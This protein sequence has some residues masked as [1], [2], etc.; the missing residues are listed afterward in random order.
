MFL[1]YCLILFCVRIEV[2]TKTPN[3]TKNY[4]TAMVSRLKPK[5]VNY[6]L[7]K[8]RNSQN[9][10]RSEDYHP[11]K[12]LKVSLVRLNLEENSNNIINDD[13]NDKFYKRFKASCI[14]YFDI[15]PMSSEISK[16]ESCNVNDVRKKQNLAPFMIKLSRAGK[17]IHQIFIA[18]QIIFICYEKMNKQ[19]VISNKISG[20]NRIIYRKELTINKIY[21]QLKKGYNVSIKQMLDVNIPEKEMLYY[22]FQPFYI[23]ERILSNIDFNILNEKYIIIEIISNFVVIDLKLKEIRQFMNSNQKIH[24]ENLRDDIAIT[25]TLNDIQILLLMA[26]SNIEELVLLKTT[27]KK[28]MMFE[29]FANISDMCDIKNKL[30]FILLVN[31]D[32][33]KMEKYTTEE[34]INRFLKI[35]FQNRENEGDIIFH[36]VCK[37]EIFNNFIR[38]LM[39]FYNFYNFSSNDEIF[40]RSIFEKLDKIILTS[41]KSSLLDNRDCYVLYDVFVRIINFQMALFPLVDTYFL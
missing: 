28:H 30:L 5:I 19:N 17:H 25:S 35:D 3:S 1:F 15:Q 41:N 7:K 31:E 38:F 29:L 27:N 39:D 32:S 12:I 22:I 18:N 13:K 34:N 40:W 4:K 26:I 37:K 33:I 36:N 24:M 10:L 6:G 9:L 2:P 20:Y 14:H 23:M 16:H 8:L 11:K 21:K